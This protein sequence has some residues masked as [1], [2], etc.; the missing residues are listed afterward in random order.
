MRFFGRGILGKSTFKAV[1]VLSLAVAA[2]A[3]TSAK[4]LAQQTQTEEMERRAKVLQALPANA[5]KRIFGT[6]PAPAP[7]AARAIGSFARGCLAGAT[8][9]PGR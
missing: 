8:A 6:N 9:I 3:L 1:M 2:T 5:A 7:L 4:S